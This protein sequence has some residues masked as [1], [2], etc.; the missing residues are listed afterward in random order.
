MPKKIYNVEQGQINV[1]YFNVDIKSVRQRRSNFFIFKVE[2]QNVD[3]CRNNV[4]NI[5]KSMKL[6]KLKNKT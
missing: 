4:V 5:N 1:V 6:N 3:Q 2:F